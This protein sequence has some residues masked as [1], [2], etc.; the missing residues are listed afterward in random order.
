MLLQAV[1]CALNRSA[2]LRDK[3]S[4]RTAARA[5]VDRLTP[6][7]FEVLQRV[8][9]GLLNKQIAAEIGAAEKTVKVH[10]G[11]VMTKLEADSLVELIRVA[12]IAGV[13]LPG[14]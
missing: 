8:M 12:Q 10:R 7:E 5:K 2:E 1:N 9:T 13:A 6:R 3:K 11:R 4:A 14:G